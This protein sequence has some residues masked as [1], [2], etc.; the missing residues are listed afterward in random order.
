MKSCHRLLTDSHLI[1]EASILPRLFV[2]SLPLFIFAPSAPS[3]SSPP[4][5]ISLSL[6]LPCTLC[7]HIS[8]SVFLCTHM[9]VIFIIYSLFIW[10]VASLL[11]SDPRVKGM[12][13]FFM[14][15]CWEHR[16]ELPRLARFLLLSFSVCQLAERNLGPVR[17]CCTQANF[18]PRVFLHPRLT[19]V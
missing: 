16:S 19:S 5:R 15:I 3:P 14:G 10:V 8:V 12:C 11:K 2:C 4:L 6:S 7:L 17:I 13:C 18:L 9:R 1:L